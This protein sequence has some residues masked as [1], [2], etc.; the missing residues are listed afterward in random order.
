M[1]LYVAYALQTHKRILSQLLRIGS[2][3]H[4]HFIGSSLC[5]VFLLTFSL[6]Y[7]WKWSVLR[8]M[9]RSFFQ[10]SHR[11]L[12]AGRTIFVIRANRQMAKEV[13]KYVSI[14]MNTQ[15]CPH[16]DCLLKG[17]YDIFIYLEIVVLFSHFQSPLSARVNIFFLFF[18]IYWHDLFLDA[19]TSKWKGWKRDKTDKQRQSIDLLC[20]IDCHFET[21][22]LLICQSVS[23]NDVCGVKYQHQRTGKI[24]ANHVSILFKRN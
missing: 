12:N 16:G 7:R 10:C 19:I 9:L 17:G 15:R 8:T 6:I 3:R 18:F 2:M 21:K 22:C 4:K 24:P 11:D 13:R 1:I 23:D 20:R 5:Y 14:R